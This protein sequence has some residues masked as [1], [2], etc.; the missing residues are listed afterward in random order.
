MIAAK[1][2]RDKNIE[3]LLALNTTPDSD[4]EDGEGDDTPG[5][6][7]ATDVKSKSAKAA[8]HYAALRGHA[9]SSLPTPFSDDFVA[10][11]HHPF[12]L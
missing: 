4:D 5:A 10:S 9:V 3:A 8:I 7:V 6:R 1:Y 12:L 11:T 2:G